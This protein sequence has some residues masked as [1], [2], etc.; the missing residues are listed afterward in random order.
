MTEL[1]L[2]PA[3]CYPVYPAIAAGAGCAPGGVFVDAG[4]AWVFRH[5]PSHDP[6]RRQMF[7]QHELVRI[8]EPEAVLEWRDEWA[9]RGLE[10]LRGLGLDAKLDNANDPF[11][12][13][14]G[15]MLAANQRERARSS[16][17]C[18]CRSRGPSRRRSRRS[19]TIATT[20]AATYGIELADGGTAHTACLGFGHER[21]VLAL[22]RTHGLDTTSWPDEVKHKLSAHERVEGDRRAQPVGLRSRRLPAAP[23]ARR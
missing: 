18:W 11:F 4:G 22:L 6:A 15:R 14:R 7:H 3:A 1:A 19:T 17:S 5:E 2:M 20:S 10:L 9:Q 12:G 21:I 16:S 8:A 13:R 23:A